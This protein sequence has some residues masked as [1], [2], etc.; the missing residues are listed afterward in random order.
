M[1]LLSKT[2][3]LQRRISQAMTCSRHFA[4]FRILTVKYQTLQR[5]G[6]Q[7]RQGRDART[8]LESELQMMALRCMISAQSDSEQRHSKEV[9]SSLASI[10][11]E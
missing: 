10:P 7:L 9:P 1:S 2:I 4:L 5:I 6:R 3:A 8:V 11:E